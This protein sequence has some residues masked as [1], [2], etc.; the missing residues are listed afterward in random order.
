MSFRTGIRS[1]QDVIPN[2]RK[3][4]VRACPEQLS[5]A[6][7]SNG[8]LL[9][10]RPGTSCLSKQEKPH[11]VSLSSRANQVPHPSP[12]LRS[13][14]RSRSKQGS[15]QSADNLRRLRPRNSSRQQAL[16]HFPQRPL[17]GFRVIQ[18]DR[19]EVKYATWGQ[20]YNALHGVRG[21]MKSLLIER[22]RSRI[23]LRGRVTA[24]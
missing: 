18:I 19:L 5:V 6:K 21:E 17:H 16:D 22:G 4:R 20:I 24:F 11:A 3:A 13:V 10:P 9:F 2:T 12:L 8:N 15:P 1:L 23:T 14:G 7:E